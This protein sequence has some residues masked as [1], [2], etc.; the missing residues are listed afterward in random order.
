MRVDE[1]LA[2]LCRQR[3]V[4]E[5]DAV[6]DGAGGG[7]DSH[8]V[9]VRLVGFPRLGRSPCAVVRGGWGEVDKTGESLLAGDAR[10]GVD[11]P[12]WVGADGVHLRRRLRRHPVEVFAQRADVPARDPGPR[13][14]RDGEEEQAG[15]QNDPDARVPR[16][17]LLAAGGAALLPRAPQVRSHDGERTHPRGREFGIPAAGAPQP[18]AAV[19]LG[20]PR[21][22]RQCAGGAVLDE[23]AAHARV[24]GIDEDGAGVAGVGQRGIGKQHAGGRGGVVGDLDLRQL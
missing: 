21:A 18:E 8:G 7:I 19:P 11:L 4:G 24:A 13:K 12:G 16:E 1:P 22:Q 20:Q 10:D 2:E 3:P 17:H 5:V 23:V 15:Q 9:H 6:D 14:A